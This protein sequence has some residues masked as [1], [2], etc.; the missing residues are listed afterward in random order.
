MPLH[1]D[2]S[3]SSQ[4]DLGFE[5]D[6]T[7]G[8]LF[9]L[10]LNDLVPN[11]G[12]HGFLSS[13][14]N[15]NTSLNLARPQNQDQLISPRTQPTSLTV[16][17]L[18]LCQRVREVRRTYVP[19]PRRS[20]PVRGVVD[21]FPTQIPEDLPLTEVSVTEI[22]TTQLIIATATRERIFFPRSDENHMIQG[23]RSFQSRSMPLSNEVNMIS[24]TSQEEPISGHHFET[25]GRNPRPIFIHHS[26][27]SGGNP[28]PIFINHRSET[29]GGN[30]N[31]IFINHHSET[32]G[33][34]P[35]PIFINH[36]SE[37][38]GGNPSPIFNQFQ[39]HDVPDHLGLGSH[40]QNQRASYSPSLYLNP[41]SKRANGLLHIDD[42]EP[43]ETKY[44]ISTD[45]NQPQRNTTL[46]NSHF[47]NEFTSSLLRDSDPIK[48][49]SSDDEDE[50]EG[51][52]HTRSLRPCQKYGPYI[53]PRC[54]EVFDTAQFFAAHMSSHYSSETRDERRKRQAAKYKKKRTSLRLVQMGSGVT[55]LPES[56]NAP[57][58]RVRRN[59]R[60]RGQID[61]R[62]EDQTGDGA[63]EQ[64]KSERQEQGRP[65][66]LASE[67]GWIDVKIKEEPLGP[68][69]K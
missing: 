11:Y 9:S 19:T 23:Q 40:L 6:P 7:D 8:E 60:M 4:I 64:D 47:M 59:G 67:E 35:N 24:F 18:G 44:Q 10:N 33:G 38:S 54:K 26:E 37:T 48:I 68:W 39:D 61:I 53:C 13:L 14:P 36:H 25:S 58:I 51:R 15:S 30:P 2:A 62:V 63:E 46:H 16:S 5:N 52:G 20:V 32:S 69:L 45:Q 41:P 28:S 42:G 65:P 22:L 66:G 49:N 57:R 50:T 43:M 29:S 17:Q 12:D 56:Y 34:N 31:P 3:M 1:F 27:S 55:V 21:Y